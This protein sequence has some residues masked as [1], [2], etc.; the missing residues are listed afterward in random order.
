MTDTASIPMTDSQRITLILLVC[1]VGFLV[2]VKS[3]EHR[4]QRQYEFQKEWNELGTR[5]YKEFSR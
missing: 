2:I 4:R 5:I 3:N 1:A